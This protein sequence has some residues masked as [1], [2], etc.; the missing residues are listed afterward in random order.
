M[1]DTEG[2]RVLNS[3]LLFHCRL[4]VG[5]DK[6]GYYH[7]LFLRGRIDLVASIQRV[8][9]KGTGVRAKANPADEPNLYLFPGV[10]G[11][12]AADVDMDMDIQDEKVPPLEKTTKVPD[13]PFPTQS[14][15]TSQMMMVTRDYDKVQDSLEQ[16]AERLLA[17]QK[18]PP[19]PAKSQGL[20]DQV[21]TSAAQ[22]EALVAESRTEGRRPI[23]VNFDRLIDEMF[24]HDQSLDFADLLKLAAV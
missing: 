9:V 22:V 1:H 17:D 14:M 2:E 12:P 4:T 5:P 6:G 23:D 10:D 11:V 20:L 19:V 13:M 8:K 7:E 16:K 3:I 24:R 18:P 21:S 15:L